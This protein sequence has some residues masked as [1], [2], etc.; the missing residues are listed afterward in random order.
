MC[1]LYGAHKNCVR[2]AFDICD[3]VKHG[4]H[5]VAEVNIGN[6]AKVEHHICSFSSAIVVGVRS[7]VVRARVSFCFDYE[8]AS[9]YIVKMG[10]KAFA[11]QMFAYEHNILSNEKMTI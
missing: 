5:A 8:T 2:N 1:G 3:D 4:M 9:D 6:T 11:E 10:K 7:L